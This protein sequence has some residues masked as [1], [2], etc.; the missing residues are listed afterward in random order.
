MK[1]GEFNPF[2]YRTNFTAHPDLREAQGAFVRILLDEE[3]ERATSNSLLM[4]LDEICEG[5]YLELET[6]NAAGQ[7]EKFVFYKMPLPEDLVGARDQ[8]VLWDPQG[9]L[10]AVEPLGACTEWGAICDRGNIRHGVP[11]LYHKIALVRSMDRSDEAGATL[12]LPETLETADLRQLTEAGLIVTGAD[13]L[14]YWRLSLGQGETGAVERA[15]RHV[16]GERKFLQ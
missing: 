4:E 7:D 1:G 9:G 2:Q 16:Y 14:P 6:K 10:D 15:V 12:P 8:W 3:I 13:Y 5:N 11:F